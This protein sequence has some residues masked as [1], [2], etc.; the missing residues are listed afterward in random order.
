MDKS[1]PKIDASLTELRGAA[2]LLAEMLRRTD[3]DAAARRLNYGAYGMMQSRWGELAH[4]ALR[5]AGF[6]LEFTGS[7]PVFMFRGEAKHG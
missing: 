1:N 4:I 2:W 5:E 7:G 6:E 3:S